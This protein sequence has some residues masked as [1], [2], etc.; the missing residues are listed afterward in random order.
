[1]LALDSPPHVDEL[2][3]HVKAAAPESLLVMQGRNTD[4]GATYTPASFSGIEA[5][6]V[7]STTL[8]PV[9]ADQRVFKTEAEV[10]VM[11]YA[12]D[13]S[14]EAHLAVMRA[15]KAG[16]WEFQLESIF[17]VR[18]TPVATAAPSACGALTHARRRSHSTP[19][20]PWAARA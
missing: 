9:L 3:G 6:R 20:T 5:F 2:E 1:M 12:N 7:D 18:P 10:A 17:R 8:F 16:M 4:S 19:A 11:R 14:S 13:L 15:C